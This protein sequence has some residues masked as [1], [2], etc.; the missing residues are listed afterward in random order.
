MRIFF[1]YLIILN[2]AG[3]IFMWSD[4]RKA[5]RHAWRTPEKTLFGIALL[6]GSAGILAGMYLF[7][8]KTKHMSF[9]IGVPVILML[10]ISGFLLI[11][12]YLSF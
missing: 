12:R 8:H 3:L 6:G 7:R 9:V 2:L 10:Q 4:K 1:F 5:I 11:L